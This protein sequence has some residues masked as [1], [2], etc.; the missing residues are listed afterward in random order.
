MKTTHLLTTWALSALFVACTADEFKVANPD[1]VSQDRAKVHPDFVLLTE[2]LQTRYAVEGG[3]GISFDFEKGDQMGA[4][5]IDK[6][7]EG[8]NPEDFNVTYNIQKGYCMDYQ[9]NGE[10]KPNAQLDA[11]HYLFV[12]PFNPEDKTD[13]Q[14][15]Y[16]GSNA[17]IYTFSSVQEMYYD[18]DRL[19]VLNAA[20]EKGNQAIGA[21]V[22]H[23]GEQ[24]AEVGLK[25]L[26]TYP[27]MV[28]YFDSNEPVTSVSQIVLKAETAE[29]FLVKGEFDHRV[30]S[31]MFAGNYNGNLTGK[32]YWNETTQTVDWDKVGTYDF[33]PEGGAN[34][35]VNRESSDHI[36][37]KFADNAKVGED[38]VTKNKFVEARIMMPSIDNFG[39]EL[40]DPSASTGIV[41]YVY[42]N[43][44]VYRTPFQA[45]SFDFKATTD[46]E[47]QQAALWRN[48]SNG[49]T[50]KP[51]TADN[52][53]EDVEILVTNQEEWNN[54][55]AMY[56]NSGV[57]QTVAIVGDEFVFNEETQWPTNCRFYLT[58][59]VSV[60]GNVEIQNV[61]VVEI[62]TDGNLVTTIK[63]GATLI[64]N[65]TFE[66]IQVNN[67]GTLLANASVSTRSEGY[68]DGIY[69]VSNRNR[70]D[71]Y[72]GAKVQFSRLET[73]TDAVTNNYGEISGNIYNYGTINNY[74]VMRISGANVYQNDGVGW[75]YN[76]QNAEIWMQ[77]YFGNSSNIINEGTM[78][79]VDPENGPALNNGYITSCI[80]A[81][82][83]VT[84][85]NGQIIVYSADAAGLTVLNTGEFGRVT[86]TA[87][88]PVDDFTN[89]LVDEVTFEEDY[90]ILGGEINF[91]DFRGSE[92]TLTLNNPEDPSAEGCKVEDLR[93]VRG[94]LTLG[95]DATFESLTVWGELIIP[96]GV[97]LTCNGFPEYFVNSGRI[98]VRG[99][100]IAPNIMEGGFN[101]DGT[102]DIEGGEV[103]WGN[104]SEESAE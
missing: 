28:I 15:D 50:L 48:H 76:A 77:Y 102:I 85:N 47:K 74:G 66:A 23:E 75:I 14:V 35:Y 93:I 55:V 16:F 80:G 68:Y 26:F 99:T 56:G 17:V 95:S 65:N 18:G 97:T 53:T 86:Y 32:D 58:T 101:G 30:V 24:V 22:L 92:A 73:T 42:T 90:T 94:K 5:L 59:D 6:Y 71:I 20:I 4:V 84:E 64:L 29:P 91:L 40:D 104:Q 46:K 82:T 37:V 49:L 103:I 21:A 70:M 78:T 34:S 61:S 1:N 36:V 83:F 33:L 13:N 45:S 81:T 87:T 31:D 72:E 54:L 27:K 12:Y 62:G 38:Y 39:P 88:Q 8:M 10:W 100:L 43:N 9:E 3:A 41:M 69:F 63:E 98:V 2:D 44:G 25:N 96:E 79:C 67:H 51:L 60:E 57:D 19:H 89:S 11:G 52:K 7:E